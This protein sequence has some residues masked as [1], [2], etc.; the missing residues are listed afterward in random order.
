MRLKKNETIGACGIDCG[1]CPRFYTK[2]DSRCPGCGGM[3]FKDKHPTCGVLTCCVIK[4]G[5]EVCAECKDFPCKRFD[6]EKEGYDSFVTHQKMFVNMKDIKENGME[7][8]IRR[9]KIR[10]DILDDLLTHHDDG[11]AKSFFCQCCALLPI[12][13]LQ[14]IHHDVK[15][16]DRQKELKERTGH[17]RKT[18]TKVAESEQIDLGLKKKTKK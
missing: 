18:L 10:M 5:F 1:L 17:I 11:R 16:L 15:G 13:K 3:N 7:H 2:G 14:E 12:G 6:A 8:F 9:Q 4:N